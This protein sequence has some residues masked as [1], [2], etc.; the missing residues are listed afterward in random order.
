[1]REYRDP[2]LTKALLLSVIG[3][4][5]ILCLLIF[6]VGPHLGD[7]PPNV[8]YSV[9][10][11]GGKDKGGISQVPDK[12]KK[13]Q[14]S[15]PKKAKA[16]PEKKKEP[17]KEKKEEKK[18]VKE[19]K[20][21]ESEDAEVSLKEKKEEKKPPPKKVV[22]K[23]PPKK[24]PPKKKTTSSKEINKSYQ[25]AMQRYLGESTNAGG[26]GFG[27]DGR[28]GSGRGGGL[29][30]SP[31]WF[32]YKNELEL[33]VKRGWNW[34]DRNIPLFS[35]VSFEI[36]RAGIVSNIQLARSSGNRKYD[37]SVLRAV[38]KAS[39]VPPAPENLY[40]DFRFVEIDFRPQ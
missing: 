39:P 12:K 29:V 7:I 1:L 13:T 38:G 14:I 24:T 3:H 19:E 11:E 31:E 4:V 32:L 26:I 37:N 8:I 5:V 27:S 36:S 15:P 6:K 22:K 34:H 20:K 30:R 2:H 16:E 23:P 40:K 33:Y 25:D 10:L 9:T 18:P 28:G 17:P 35:S 21:V